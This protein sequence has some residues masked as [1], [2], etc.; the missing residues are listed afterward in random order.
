MD[1][2]QFRTKSLGGFSSGVGSLAPADTFAEKFPFCL[3]LSTVNSRL[4][5][6]NR[7]LIATPWIRIPSNSLK[8]NNADSL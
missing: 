2:E 5:T 1:G 8:T 4:S 6:L 3:S 7:I